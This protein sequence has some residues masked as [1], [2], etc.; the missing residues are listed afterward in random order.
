MAAWINRTEL[1]GSS[2]DP[3]GTITHTC[4][5]TAA[6]SGNL[7]VAIIAGAVISTTPSGWT[8]VNSAING[9]IPTSGNR[10]EKNYLYVSGQYTTYGAYY[11]YIGSTDSKTVGLAAPSGQKYSIAAIEIVGAPAPD[12]LTALPWTI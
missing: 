3:N 11:P 1:S 2:I 4:T 6:A 9:T 8:L 5:F 7:L 12:T 10:L